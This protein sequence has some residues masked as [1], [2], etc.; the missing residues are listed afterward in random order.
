[1]VLS[2]WNN[3]LATQNPYGH[4]N[5]NKNKQEQEQE[6]EPEQEQQ[7]QQQQQQNQMKLNDKQMKDGKEEVRADKLGWYEFM[8][9]CCTVTCP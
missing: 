7:Q 3:N 4:H 8:V 5:H 2:D 1:M 9:T 6:Q